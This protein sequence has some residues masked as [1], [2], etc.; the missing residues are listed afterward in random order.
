MDCGDKNCLKLFRSFDFEE[1]KE[2]KA[3]FQ[4]ELR[5]KKRKIV[6]DRVRELGEFDVLGI[7]RIG[8]DDQALKRIVE[9][10][11]REDLGLV[12]ALEEFLLLASY[13]QS[14]DNL[15]FKE[16]S[17][18]LL[19]FFSMHNLIGYKYL[20]T[21]PLIEA[22]FQVISSSI[23]S[24]TD[25]F[26]DLIKNSLCIIGNLAYFNKEVSAQI[27]ESNLLNELFI[28]GIDCTDDITD[29]FYFSI[30]CILYNFSHNFSQVHSKYLLKGLSFNFLS[31]RSSCMG[32]N[33]I[34]NNLEKI[35]FNKKKFHQL[36]EMSLIGD[37]EIRFIT[38]EILEIGFN[39]G[40]F[41]NFSDSEGIRKLFK[42]LDTDEKLF[43]L[44]IFYIWIYTNDN[45]KGV[46]VDINFLQKILG[47]LYVES[48]SIKEIVLL[49]LGNLQLDEKINKK[50]DEFEWISSICI[51][52]ESDHP[53]LVCKC[54][55]LVYNIKLNQKS[56]SLL[57]NSNLLAIL[58][59][60]CYHPNETISKKS[61]YLVSNLQVYT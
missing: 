56:E 44:R 29:K 42:G 36:I 41:N 35:E 7:G 51:V 53:E 30:S 50:L 48:F 45:I 24:Q 21:F 40:K 58:E 32:L 12:L 47:F 59:S 1:F 37:D 25:L 11:A 3:Q 57:S 15:E 28:L 34:K 49:I 20:L 18:K 27:I 22:I 9:K 23:K 46:L 13:Y 6:S 19:L 31:I 55:D 38:F 5:R 39:K 61:L 54:L 16:L 17:S 2:C 4:R 43:Y 8:M 52:L 60:L 26:A 14:D 10:A 33:A